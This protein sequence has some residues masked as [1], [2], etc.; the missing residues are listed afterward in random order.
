MSVYRTRELLPALLYPRL[1]E[2]GIVPEVFVTHMK[3]LPNSGRKYPPIIYKH[4]NFSSIG[5]L[6]EH[7]VRVRLL[8]K[9]PKQVYTSEFIL[10][11]VRSCGDN[12]LSQE[13]CQNLIPFL[14]K[15]VESVIPKLQD[16][17]PEKDYI[18]DHEYY[19]V[20]EG[21]QGHPDLVTSSCV[22]DVKHVSKFQETK[23]TAVVRR[24]ETKNNS[25][26][27][28]LTYF[29]LAK[30]A[31]HNPTSV[32]LILPMQGVVMTEDVSDWDFTQY[33]SLLLQVVDNKTQSIMDPM[34]LPSYLT[35][36]QSLGSHI[37][38]AMLADIK[39]PSVTKNLPDL[40][41]RVAPMNRTYQVYLRGNQ[42]AY[43]KVIF[44]ESA[45]NRICDALDNSRSKLFVHGALDINIADSFYD[46][47]TFTDDLYL[48]DQMLGSGVVIHVGKT[49]DNKTNL[50]G[51]KI[52]KKNI[53]RII[54][55]AYPECPLLLET[56]AGQGTE[57]LSNLTAFCDFYNSFSDKHKTKFK[58]C[59]DTC[60]VFSAGYNPLYYL[61]E[62]MRRCGPVVGLVH[63]NNSRVPLGQCNDAHSH[64]TGYISTSI[65]YSVLQYCLQHN[66]P[67]VTE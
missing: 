46:L 26:L 25:I 2:D 43:R 33:Y 8:D 53:R 14:R 45:L 51:I 47:K 66:I 30:L 57:L 21:I 44:T 37:S 63:F 34:I 65:M 31:G 32:G 1:V 59:V 5:L 54:R 64:L 19:Q 40:I 58:I 48:C 38:V 18:F 9:T 28:V 10:S 67:M 52:M 17:H 24:N 3:T 61:T 11:L 29:M 20:E 39:S 36:A 35:L 22:Y 13:E 4:K 50:E 60:H 55:H 27:Q 15:N 49:K 62:L 42:G 12:C 16:L 7:L 6:V 41:E 23:Q 56:P